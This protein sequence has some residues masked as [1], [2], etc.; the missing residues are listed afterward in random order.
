MAKP[1]FSK[2]DW[3]QSTRVKH[4]PAFAGQV[5]EVL[6]GGEYVVRDAERRRWLRKEDELSPAK[7]KAAND[8][9]Q[10]LDNRARMQHWRL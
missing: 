9:E 2:G 5:I 7:P 3:V 6:D 10:A 1:K 8:N 4:Q